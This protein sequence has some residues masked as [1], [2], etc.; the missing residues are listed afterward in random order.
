MF[1]SNFAK[2]QEWASVSYGRIFKLESHAPPARVLK[3]N[4][5]DDHTGPISLTWL[6]G[7]KRTNAITNFY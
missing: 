7:Y 1:Y 3:I 4:Y 6:K 2:A 5:Q